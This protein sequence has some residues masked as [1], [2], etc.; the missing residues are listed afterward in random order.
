ML[1]KKE[2]V[3]EERRSD[4]GQRGLRALL[5]LDPMGL[6]CYQ[7]VHFFLQLLVQSHRWD[8]GPPEAGDGRIAMR[9]DPLA[10]NDAGEWGQRWHTQGSGW[11]RMA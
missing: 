9:V 11:T 1:R 6:S 7:P 5:R 4:K 2:L 3:T 10:Q 8:I